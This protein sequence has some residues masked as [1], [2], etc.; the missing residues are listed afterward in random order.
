MKRILVITGILALLWGCEDPLSSTAVSQDEKIDS[1]ISS[2]YADST[3]VFNRGVNRI[4][5]SA[6]DSTRVA[7][8]GDTLAFDYIGYTFNSDIESAFCQGSYRCPL[9]GGE[10]IDAL[11]YGLEGMTP[12]E[13]SYIIASCKYC[14]GSTVAGV[15]RDKALVFEVLL[16]EIIRPE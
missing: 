16:N 6:G 4:V 7:A 5:L 2:K 12:G 11:E 3:V 1:F 9:G 8:T 15:G 10:L 13:H 14:Y